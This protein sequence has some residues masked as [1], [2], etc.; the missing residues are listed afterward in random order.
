M[1]GST[2]WHEPAK[3][4]YISI[5]VN[6]KRFRLWKDRD[7]FQ[8]FLTKARV[9]KWLSHAQTDIDN[10][11][12]NPKHWNPDSPVILNNYY[13]EWIGIKDAGKK[14]VRDYKGYFKNHILPRIGHCDIRFIRANDLIKLKKDLEQTLKPKTVYNVMS[15]FRTMFKDAYRNEDIQKIPPFPKMSNPVMAKSIDSLT[16]EQQEI[17]IDAIPE[18]HRPIFQI[19]MEYGLRVGEVRAIQKACITDTQIIIKRAFSDN[20]LKDTKTGEERAYDLTKYAKGIIG[21]IEPHLSPFLF[22]RQDG[23]P[24][25]NKNLNATWLEASN[26]SG[27]KIKLYNA[28]RHS[29]GCQLLDMGYSERHVQEQLGHKNSEM[30]RRY[31]KHSKPVLTEAL[32][33]RRN[34]IPFKKKEGR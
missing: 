19:G 27:I 9:R 4:W 6:G 26:K 1:G 34:I 11:V 28:L 16:L 3:R 23:K 18:R 2:H 32:E 24:Y 20:D 33:D 7:T 22:V 30:T 12:F 25:T 8:P 15:S 21:N 10:G 14:C 5:Y 29:L 17:M 13:K 31:A